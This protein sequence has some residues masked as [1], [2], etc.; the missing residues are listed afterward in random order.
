M[1]TVALSL[2]AAVV[3]AFGLR[4]SGLVHSPYALIAPGLIAFVGTALLLLRRA[5]RMVEPLVKEAE[6]HIKGG[7]VEMALKTLEGGLS[8]GAWHPLV[9]AQ[10]RS[11]MGQLYFDTGKLD[12][13]E[14]HLAKALRWPWTG[15]ALLGI[16]Y[17]RKRDEPRMI[18]AFET[19]CSVGDKEPLSWTLYAH[20]MLARGKR[21]EAAA[22]LERALKKNPKDNRLETNLELA[23]T[24]KKLKT[25]PYGDKWSRFGLDGSAPAQAA[26]PKA[27][28]G[29]AV[30]PGFRQRSR[31]K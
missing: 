25:A 4:L 10:L 15:K 11:M 2:L 18:K 26:L 22:I 31:K 29:F 20:C 8:I 13:A 7:R 9:P 24:G 12:L 19:A 17:F 3:V 23:K 6:G 28:R 30:R 27:A 21:D 16:C 14:E 5:S 1:L